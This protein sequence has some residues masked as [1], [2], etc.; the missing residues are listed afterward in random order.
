[1]S[2]L[3]R[4]IAVVACVLSIG[5]A[6][7]AAASSSITVTGDGISASGGTA[8]L[9]PTTFGGTVLSLSAQDMVCGDDPVGVISPESLATD[10]DVKTWATSDPTTLTVDMLID[11]VLSTEYAGGEATADF[12][13]KLELWQNRNGAGPV[14]RSS[15]EK[16]YSVSVADGDDSSAT[17]DALSLTLST[18]TDTVVNGIN[19]GTLKLSVSGAVM[20]KAACPPSPTPDP[21]PAPG[22][23]LLGS[24]GVGLVGWIRRRRSI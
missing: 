4:S 7:H 22:A 3:L 19:F 1:M 13:A 6:A 16:A 23:V 11:H 24:L 5:G 20:A 8:T 14:L 10:W 21:I 17:G 12:T 9:D 2:N 18:P 15:Q